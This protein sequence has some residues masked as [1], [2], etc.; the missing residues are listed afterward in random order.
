MYLIHITLNK[1][2]NGVK[3]FDSGRSREFYGTWQ[4][5]YVINTNFN[6]FRGHC[7]ICWLNNTNMDDFKVNSSVHK[8]AKYWVQFLWRVPRYNTSKTWEMEIEF[9]RKSELKSQN[10]SGWFSGG[11][12]LNL[13]C[14]SNKGWKHVKDWL[15]NSLPKS[16]SAFCQ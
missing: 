16:V 3:Y 11:S 8:I 2:F 13:V 5:L 10:S 7:F 1:E 9:I 14:F 12:S 6:N 15:N 4:M